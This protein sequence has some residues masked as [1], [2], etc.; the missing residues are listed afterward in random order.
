MS[1]LDSNA[2]RVKR[3]TG[4]EIWLFI[5]ARVLLGF[6]VG[7]LSAHYFPQIAGPLGFPSLAAG[8]VL[9]LVA[10]KGLRRSNSK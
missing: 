10:A 7:L 6:G 4:A 3:L 8:L 2:E 9:F 1:M 5:V